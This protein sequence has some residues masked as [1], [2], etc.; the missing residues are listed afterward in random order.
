MLDVAEKRLVPPGPRSYVVH[1]GG[2]VVLGS[3]RGGLRSSL[4]IALLPRAG[5]RP[6]MSG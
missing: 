4:A 1:R 3:R 6:R 2:V 5:K